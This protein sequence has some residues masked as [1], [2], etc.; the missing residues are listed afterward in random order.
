LRIA[1]RKNVDR[2]IR[3][4]GENLFLGNL[5]IGKP[6]PSDERNAWDANLP[7]QDPQEP[8]RG[9]HDPHVVN[10]KVLP[11]QMEETRIIE[12]KIESG[13]LPQCSFRSFPPSSFYQE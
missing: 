13:S 4:Y 10:L 6:L 12:K 3:R 5:P 7:P 2:Q 8:A 1:R 9:K 11:E